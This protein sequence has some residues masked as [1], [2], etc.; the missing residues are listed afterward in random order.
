M[1]IDPALPP[2]PISLIELPG[3]PPLLHWVVLGG[4]NFC[5]PIMQLQQKIEKAAA[6]AENMR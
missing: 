5:H 1:G 4:L 2:T 6:R 3:N